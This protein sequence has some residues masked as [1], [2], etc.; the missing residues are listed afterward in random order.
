MLVIMARH[1]SATQIQKSDSE[2]LIGRARV[3]WRSTDCTTLVFMDL[4]RTVSSATRTGFCTGRSDTGM[5]RSMI[6][7]NYNYRGFVGTAVES[8]LAVD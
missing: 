5:K 3:N 7:V 2:D 6:I 8:A 4:S 1:V